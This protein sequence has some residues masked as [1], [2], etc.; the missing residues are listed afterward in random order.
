MGKYHSLKNKSSTTYHAKNVANMKKIL[1]HLVSKI[2][3]VVDNFKKCLEKLGFINYTYI[4]S[5]DPLSYGQKRSLVCHII[6]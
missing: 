6:K 1:V 5:I 2:P 4:Y 3:V